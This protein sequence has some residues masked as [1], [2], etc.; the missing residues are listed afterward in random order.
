MFRKWRM[1]EWKD[2]MGKRNVSFRAKLIIFTIG[3][4]QTDL[5]KFI[6][7]PKNEVCKYAK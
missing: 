6:N 2:V 7:N 1:G 5:D 3:H 4:T